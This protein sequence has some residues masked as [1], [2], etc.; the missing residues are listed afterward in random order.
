M[1]RTLTSGLHNSLGTT[2]EAVCLIGRA[3]IAEYEEQCESGISDFFPDAPEQA[4]EEGGSLVAHPPADSVQ[5]LAGA[6]SRRFA[7]ERAVAGRSAMR[8]AGRMGLG[9]SRRYRDSP[10][11]QVFV[12]QW[13]DVSEHVIP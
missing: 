13:F 8:L 2:P 1:K 11:D 5:R 6:L 10:R 4:A 12:K 9:F 7:S 3:P